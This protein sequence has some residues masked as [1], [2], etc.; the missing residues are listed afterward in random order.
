MYSKKP[1]NPGTSSGAAGGQ[2]QRTTTTHPRWIFKALWL[3]TLVAAGAIAFAN[4]RP[5]VNLVKHLGLKFLDRFVL[6]FLASIPIVNAI[7]A[8]G[9]GLVTL[10]CGVALWGV[11]QIIEVLPVVLYNHAGFLE[12]VIGDAESGRKYATK[13]DDD[14]T[15]RGL[16]EVYNKL[17]VAFLENLAKVRAIAYALDFC[18]CFWNYSPVKSGRIT[19]FFYVLSTGQWNK[20]DFSNLLLALTTLFGVEISIML[21]LWVGKLAFTMKRAA[22]KQ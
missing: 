11:F 5:Y 1:N 3:V 12:E 21:L 17:P 14:P 13:H 2:R 8:A 20:I 19:D 15:V 16:K 6:Q 10:V 18:I 7:A 9:G 22:D 4:V